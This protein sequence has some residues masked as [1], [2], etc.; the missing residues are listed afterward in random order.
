MAERRVLW[1]LLAAVL[2]L[3]AWLLRGFD[4][5]AIDWQPAWVGRQPWRAWS[6]V[7]VHYSALH[8]WANVAGTLLV[9]ALGWAAQLPL[10]STLAWCAAWPLTQL[11]LLVQ[12]ALLHYGGLSGVLHAGVAIVAVHLLFVGNTTQRRI[13]VAVLVVLVAKVCSEA[14]WRGPLR[15]PSGWDIAVA[16]LAHA[17]GVLAGALC[18]VLAEA[19]HRRR[20]TLSL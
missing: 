15:Y 19:W 20:K 3:S 12:P 18:S 6:A 10:R 17:S 5:T 11:G 2:A 9:G 4:P 14:P 1:G 13:G 8:L 16:P 7:F